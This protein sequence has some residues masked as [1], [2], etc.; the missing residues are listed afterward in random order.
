MVNAAR[1][2]LAPSMAADLFDRDVC[3]LKKGI[4][5]SCFDYS[6]ITA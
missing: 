5:D 1:I 6:Q 3:P 2:M 4:E